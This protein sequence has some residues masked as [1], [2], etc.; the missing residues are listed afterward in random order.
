MQTRSPFYAFEKGFEEL[1]SIDKS[2]VRAEIMTTLEI[3]TDQAFLAY[4]RGCRKIEAV[5]YDSIEL[6]FAK[7]GVTK[8]WG[9]RKDAESYATKNK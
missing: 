8:P 2:K 7:Y 5:V 4:R 1:R 6:I 3:T 9:F